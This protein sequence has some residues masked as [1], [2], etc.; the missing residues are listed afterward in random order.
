LDGILGTY[1]AEV[2]PPASGCKLNNPLL[3]LWGATKRPSITFNWSKKPP[4]YIARDNPNE[5][6]ELEGW[7]CDIFVVGVHRDSDRATVDQV[8]PRQ[9]EF[10]ILASVDL[11]ARCTQQFP[12]F[13]AV[14]KYVF[15]D[16]FT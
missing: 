6:I 5:E 10:L 7:F 1:N 16:L 13:H 14:T 4:S 15:S 11:P 3:K 2:G 8:D 12:K 9:W